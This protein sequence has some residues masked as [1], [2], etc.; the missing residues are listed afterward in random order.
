LFHRVAVSR[1]QRVGYFEFSVLNENLT[2]CAF[3]AAF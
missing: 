1:S 3:Y 2:K